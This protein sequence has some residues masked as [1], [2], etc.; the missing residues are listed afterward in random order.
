M[1]NF[2]PDSSTLVAALTDMA[3]NEAVNT[4]TVLSELLSLLY[5]ESESARFMPSDHSAPLG[6]FKNPLYFSDYLQGLSTK[7]GKSKEP[8]FAA[9]VS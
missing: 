7:E 6:W 5:I 1:S 2:L 9:S 8:S 3:S 4:S